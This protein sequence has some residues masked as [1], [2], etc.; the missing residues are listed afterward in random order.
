MVKL[1]QYRNPDGELTVVLT[2]ALADWPATGAV[3]GVV[4]VGN[5]TNPVGK[6]HDKWSLE[7]FKPVTANGIR[8]AEDFV[9]FLVE[10]K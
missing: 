2:C 8:Y 1:I 6:F 4:V 10:L 7:L 3:P 9:R 5:E